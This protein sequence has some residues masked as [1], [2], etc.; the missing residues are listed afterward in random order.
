MSLLTFMCDPNRHSGWL[1]GFISKNG[2]AQALVCNEHPSFML[3]FSDT[4]A[5]AVSISFVLR[6]CLVLKNINYLLISQST[7]VSA[8]PSI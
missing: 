3:R 8:R 5:G 7:V 2:A 4:Q 6:E 1:I